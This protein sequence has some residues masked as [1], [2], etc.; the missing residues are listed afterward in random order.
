MNMSMYETFGFSKNA[1]DSEFS[2]ITI[3]RNVPGDALL[4]QM[5]SAELNN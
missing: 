3:K 5:K 1:A 4:L 2:E